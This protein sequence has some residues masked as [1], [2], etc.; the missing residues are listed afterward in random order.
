MWNKKKMQ[1]KH[2]VP[3][4][5]K[6]HC[7]IVPNKKWY[8][9]YYTL[10]NG[11]KK[12]H[13]PGFGL[14]RIK[15]INERTVEAN[16]I[17]NVLKLINEQNT[18]IFGTTVVSV[19]DAIKIAVNIKQHRTD[20]TKSLTTYS[21]IANIFVAWLTNMHLINIDVKQIDRK[22][23]MSFLDYA[24]EER[25]I[26]AKTHNNYISILRNLFNVILDRELIEINPF[27]KIPELKETETTRKAL[28]TYERNLII[29]EIRN[30]GDVWLEIAV[31]F[32]YYTLL[33]PIELRR[34][35]FKDVDFQKGIIILSG[36]QT[37]N[38]KNAGITMPE[39]MIERLM[40]LDFHKWE[41][42]LLIFGQYSK[43]HPDIAIGEHTLNNRHR[44][45]L[46]D[47]ADQFGFDYTGISLYSW[48]DT[49][50]T[51][52]LQMGLTIDELRQHIRHE[53]LK[54]TQKY[55]KKFKGINPHIQKMQ[56]KL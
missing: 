23:A 56:I 14:N 47:L 11:I 24:I 12:R 46:R 45:I 26:S 7:P 31:L 55:L 52:L 20:R 28:S 43:P 4:S 40:E 3:S 48:K 13:R 18:R 49:G 5:L 34:M 21:S 32:I 38:R 53:D 29:K 33:R 37:K 16:R 54:D 19:D 8:V 42:N 2:L 25:K 30:R 36:D 15:D 50:A 41:P 6:L 44:N 9:Q 39:T 51:D 35:R 27:S 22:V 17:L 1:I 10:H